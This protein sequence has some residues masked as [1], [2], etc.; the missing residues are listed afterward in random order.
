MLARRPAQLS[1]QF[2]T[3]GGARAGAG[4]P[5]KGKSAGVSH[6]RRPSLSHRHPVHVT[7][8]L[9]SGVPSL[10]KQALFVRV[11]SALA[12][13]QERFGFRIVHFSVQSN[14]LHL[15]AEAADRRALSRGV[16]G[17]SVRVARAV[18]SRLERKGRLLADRYHAR[19]LKSPRA[20]R[21]ALRY[22]LLNARKHLS[23]SDARQAARAARELPFGFIDS[24][25]SAAWFAGFVRQGDLAFGASEARDEWR[26]TSPLEA[27]VVKPKTWL[28][29]VGYLR[30]GA[31]DIDDV[32]GAVR[33]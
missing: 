10:R 4:R 32:P 15:I 29:R 5:P 7:L 24:R 23:V 9:T 16:Q 27:P 3:W 6:L 13:G 12:S 30:H 26:A 28:L 20:V 1:L 8:R 17:L 19:A 22:V 18:N 31:F 33:G 2:R 11:R 25:S 21:Y 14:H